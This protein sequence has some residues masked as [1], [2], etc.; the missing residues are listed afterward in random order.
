MLPTPLQI[1]ISG[2][3]GSIPPRHLKTAVK[4]ACMAEIEADWD[5]TQPQLWKERKSGE[6]WGSI[7]QDI[8][9]GL[10]TILGTIN[11]KNKVAEVR[12]I[13]R[14]GGKESYIYIMA[15]GLQIIS[16]YQI[17]TGGSLSPRPK[18]NPSTHRFQYW[19]RYTHCM[20]EAW[21]WDYLLVAAFLSSG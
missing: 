3:T 14:G 13:L 11:C 18:T 2:N 5:V 12:A 7:I 17:Y 15:T 19:K 1:S 16:H 9:T 21:G 8:H 6:G 10:K 20:D 4:T